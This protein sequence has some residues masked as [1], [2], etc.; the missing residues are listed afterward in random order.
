MDGN[1]DDFVVSMFSPNKTDELRFLV[2]YTQERELP[3]REGYRLRGGTL[4]VMHHI[5]ILFVT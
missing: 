1:R 2:A 3:P 4:I 5:G